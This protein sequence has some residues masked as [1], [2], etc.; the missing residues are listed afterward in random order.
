MTN[1]LE[2][3]MD[4]Q[5][6]VSLIALTEEQSGTDDDEDTP[7]ISSAEA[8]ASRMVSELHMRESEQKFVSAEHVKISDDG[9]V[10]MCEEVKLSTE[11]GSLSFKGE[12]S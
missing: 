10:K 1:A 8:G 11:I 2:K 6:N 7:V 5:K 12:E 4:D 3:V 9:E